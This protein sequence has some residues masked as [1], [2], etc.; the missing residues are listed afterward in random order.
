LLVDDSISFLENKSFYFDHQND[1]SF[2]RP[3]LEPP[4][5]EFDFEPN[6]GE[7]ISAVTNN[8]DELNED[9]CFDPGG[10]INV[11]TNLEDDDYFPFM[12]VI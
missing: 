10:D 3:P 4:D 11:S 1:P 2:P 5:D 8:I 12:I 9:E 6:L 7:V